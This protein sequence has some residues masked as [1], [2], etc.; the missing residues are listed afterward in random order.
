MQL[1]KVKHF[2]TCI[3]LSGRVKHMKSY[4]NSKM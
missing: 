1:A 4:A 3:D 2:L